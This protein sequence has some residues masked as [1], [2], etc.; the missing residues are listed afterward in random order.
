LTGPELAEV[1]LAIL[2]LQRKSGGKR[3]KSRLSP[4]SLL[5]EKAGRP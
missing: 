4:A 2:V 5:A 1:H 3:A